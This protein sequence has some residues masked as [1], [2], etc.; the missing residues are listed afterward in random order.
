MIAQTIK[1]SYDIVD[2]TA[3]PAD[4]KNALVIAIPFVVL[5]LWVLFMAVFGTMLWNRCLVPA[6]SV[7]R[8]VTRMQFL[9]IAIMMALM[10]L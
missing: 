2:S 9:G 7:V 1:G 6:V 4:T 8:P 5:V 3:M 10:A